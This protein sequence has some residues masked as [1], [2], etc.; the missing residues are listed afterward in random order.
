VPAW[1]IELFGG[2]CDGHVAE[3]I[4]DEPPAI[5][6]AGNEGSRGDYHTYARAEPQTDHLWDFIAVYEPITQN[7]PEGM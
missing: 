3:V 2:P 5:I 1:Q 7:Q 4:A 6:D